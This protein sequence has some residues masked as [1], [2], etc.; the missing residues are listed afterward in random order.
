MLAMDLWPCQAR[1]I[2]LK[3]IE[4]RETPIEL[5]GIEFIEVQPTLRICFSVWTEKFAAG[6]GRFQNT[7]CV[8]A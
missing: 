7:F 2:R 1:L 4:I 8:L 5:R 3:P 6:V